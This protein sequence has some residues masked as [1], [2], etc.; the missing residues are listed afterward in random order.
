MTIIRWG[1]GEERKNREEDQREGTKEG[2]KKKGRAERRNE[3]RRRGKEQKQKTRG[4]RS[5]SL[6]KAVLNQ[7]GRIGRFTCSGFNKKLLMLC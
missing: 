1:R 6:T 3:E 7:N 2:G 4:V 5:T